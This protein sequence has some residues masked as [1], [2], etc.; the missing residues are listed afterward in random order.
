MKARRAL[1]KANRQNYQE[2]ELYHDQTIPLY[3]SDNI[4]MF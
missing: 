4:T 1:A 2:I 3:L